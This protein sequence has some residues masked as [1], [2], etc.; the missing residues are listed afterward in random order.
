MKGH[1]LVVR[2]LKGEH[3]R[4]MDFLGSIDPFVHVDYVHV[5][6]TKVI[7]GNQRPQWKEE[8][9]VKFL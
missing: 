7:K 3:L 2:V 4:K 9:K 1:Q 8:I 6:E 5:K